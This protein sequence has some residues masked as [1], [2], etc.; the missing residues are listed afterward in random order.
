MV[1]SDRMWAWASMTRP[2]VM[3]VSWTCGLGASKRNGV[4]VAARVGGT[5]HDAGGGIDGD[6]LHAADL[7][8]PRQEGLDAVAALLQGS[9]R[10][11]GYAPLDLDVPTVPQP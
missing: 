3:G 11:G 10:G 7:H 2:G 9:D 1:S 4:A 8:G 5:G 6:G